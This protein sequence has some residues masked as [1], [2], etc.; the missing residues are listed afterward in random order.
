M[1]ST[2]T[3]PPSRPRSS[4]S[5][6]SHSDL[7]A[8]HTM[9]SSYEPAT[10]SPSLLVSSVRQSRN[11]FQPQPP[12]TPP[13]ECVGYVGRALSHSNKTALGPFIMQSLLILVA[14]A[15]LAASIYMVLGR[16]CLLFP[17]PIFRRRTPG[18]RGLG[19][20]Q[21]RQKH[22]YRWSHYPDHHLWFLRLR[23]CHLSQQSQQAS[24]RCE[25]GSEPE[26]A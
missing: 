9:S 22:R 4:L 19:F 1:S 5:F 18:K 24:Y 11:P 3:H 26:M 25:C 23:G 15:L 13:V 8:I 10:S 20:F 7:S 12:D 6:S 16:R 21:P 17:R 14:P 2:A